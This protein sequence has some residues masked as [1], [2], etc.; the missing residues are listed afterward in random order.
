VNWA[1]GRNAANTVA[2]TLRRRFRIFILLSVLGGASYTIRLLY[3]Q[4]TAAPKTREYF[5]DILRTGISWK[6]LR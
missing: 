2:P 6:S 3:L 5:E 4:Y 1:L